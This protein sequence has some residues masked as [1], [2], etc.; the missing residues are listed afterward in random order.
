MRKLADSTQD[1][2]LSYHENNRR[3]L[4]AVFTQGLASFGRNAL[5][6][7]KQRYERKT[8]GGSRCLRAFL[9]RGKQLV[10]SVPMFGYHQC[11]FLSFVY[12]QRHFVSLIACNGN[13]PAISN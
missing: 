9:I 10:I 4:H 3:I 7:E 12:F 11:C 1:K 6:G 8:R 5:P 2:P 13:M